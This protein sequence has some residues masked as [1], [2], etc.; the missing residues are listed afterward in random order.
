[1]T[2][3]T[4]IGLDWLIHID[5]RRAAAIPSHTGPLHAPAVTHTRQAA[6]VYFAHKHWQSVVRAATLSVQS[7]DVVETDNAFFEAGDQ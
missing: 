4:R 3:A 5:M 6:L 7:G 1:M 2:A